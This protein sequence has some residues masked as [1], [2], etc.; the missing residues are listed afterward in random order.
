VAARL[1]A[2]SPELQMNAW[3]AVETAVLLKHLL[4]LGR[5]SCVLLSPWARVLLPLPPGVKAA[6]SY[7]QLLTQ[8]GNRKTV[9]QPADQPKPLGGSCSLAK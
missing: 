8:P 3:G 7:A 5:D 9:C 6:A 4:D 2:R 1:E